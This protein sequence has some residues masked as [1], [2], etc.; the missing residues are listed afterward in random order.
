M[1]RAITDSIDNKSFVNFDFGKNLYFK[2]KNIVHVIG[3]KREI[4]R[5][6]YCSKANGYPKDLNRE[7][8]FPPMPIEITLYFSEDD[9]IIT[10]E[11]I[12]PNSSIIF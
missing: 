9:C 1:Q 10:R 5:I 12:I 6:L 7:K 4:F 2:E 8:L 3:L 11:G